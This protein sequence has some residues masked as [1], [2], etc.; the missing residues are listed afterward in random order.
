[1]AKRVPKILYHY[2]SLQTFQTII[3][4]NSIWLSDIS[5]S[6]DS[7]ELQWIKGQCEFYILKA[8]VDFLESKDDDQRFN[9]V[10]SD[11]FKKI[12]ELK[13]LIKN[14][15]NT[16][17]WA[18]CLSEKN[19]DL[20]QW[21]GYADDGAGI[22]IGFKSGTF[23]AIQAVSHY[24]D[25]ESD[26]YFKKVNY[27]KPQVHKF[28]YDHLKLNEITPEFTSEKVIEKLTKC[29]ISSIWNAPFFKNE[30]FK[31]EKEWRL[32]YSM[33]YS[34]LLHG[35]M[36]TVLP[37]TD[38]LAHSIE[39]KYGYIV[40]NNELISHIELKF[41]EIKSLISTITLGPKARMTALEL[42]EYLISK[43]ILKNVSDKS[44]KIHISGST[45]R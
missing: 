5:K 9:D 36:P 20:S 40:K 15:N 44:I 34:D 45:Y 23:E 8:W 35:I 33:S 41:Q 3:E 17:T 32:A 24:I 18:F 27:S 6:N 19:D 22:S 39:S 26:L 1:M 4:N 30:S 31:D 7:K 10:T 12:D 38:K 14:Y 42:K 16:K 11:D 25:D 13:D 37:H 28:F 43:G 29:V 21:R 2:C